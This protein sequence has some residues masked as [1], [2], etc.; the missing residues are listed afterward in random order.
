MK[1]SQT[2]K[3][4]GVVQVLFDKDDPEIEAYIRKN[5][6][7]CLEAYTSQHRF[8]SC[9]RFMECSDAGRCVHPNRLY[10]KGCIYRRN[11]ADGRIFYGKNKNIQGSVIASCG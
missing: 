4:G 3:K 9:S 2:D 7:Y 5:I 6:H 8:S 10:A 11:L 1:Q